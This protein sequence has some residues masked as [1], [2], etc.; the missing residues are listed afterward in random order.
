[1]KILNNSILKPQFYPKNIKP[2]TFKG[3][4]RTS[5]KLNSENILLEKSVEYI[6]QFYKG[7]EDIKAEIA[8]TKSNTYTRIEATEENKNKGLY[9]HKKYYLCFFDENSDMKECWGYDK[10]KG[11]IKIISQNGTIDYSA[12]ETEAL[13]FYKKFPASIH[14]KLRSNKSVYSASFLRNPNSAIERLEEIFNKDKTLKTK[15]DITLYR[16]IEDDLSQEQK[17]ALS[18]IGGI[19][20]EKSFCSTSTSI[21]VAKA[22]KGKNPILKINIPKGTKYI[23]ID[24]IFNIDR[25]RWRE[26]EFL[27]NKGVKFRVVKYLENDII[28]ADM[29]PEEK[30]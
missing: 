27:L 8:G 20:E 6:K 15:S 29:L 13:Y 22:F 10:D 26:F 17:E 21:E 2:Q 1:M 4:D 7:D 11:T 23:D 16:A 28:E 19:F 12:K 5:E 18:T 30:N 14:S 24:K 3:I 25:E 9:A